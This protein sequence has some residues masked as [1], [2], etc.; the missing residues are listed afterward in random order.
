MEYQK[1]YDILIETARILK[2][3]DILDKLELNAKNMS[4]V[5]TN[6]KIYDIIKKIVG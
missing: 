6:E 3:R 2:N 1:G 5:N 4:I